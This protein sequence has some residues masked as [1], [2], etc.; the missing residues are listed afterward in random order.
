MVSVVGWRGIFELE[1]LLLPNGRYTAIDFNPRVY[2]SLALALAAGVNLPAIWCDWLL[3][4]D[5]AR[6]P[7]PR[8]NVLYRRE[9][10]ELRNA[11]AALRGRGL[12][13]A[14]EILRPRRNVA[15]AY[16]SLR[17]P[18]PAVARAVGLTRTH[19]RRRRRG[20]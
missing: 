20:R 1:L 13:S 18:L 12:R 9:D 2:G 8:R 17:D 3:G 7:S 6:A 4:R 11:A 16:Y 5:T 19:A 15:H 10:S 14:V